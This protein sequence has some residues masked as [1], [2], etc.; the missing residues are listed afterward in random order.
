MADKSVPMKDSVLSEKDQVEILADLQSLGMSPEQIQDAMTSPDKTQM[1]VLEKYDHLIFED[2][3]KFYNA[4]RKVEWPYVG[5]C[6]HR[7][8]TYESALICANQRGTEWYVAKNVA[9]G[10]EGQLVKDCLEIEGKI[11]AL[12]ELPYENRT[13]PL[14]DQQLDQ[15]LKE[16]RKNIRMAMRMC[17]TKAI[18]LMPSN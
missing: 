6:D 14:T 11:I 15:E 17:S 8:K 2:I 4:Q 1:R 7:H 9:C 10:F 13:D 3:I 12:K 5:R 18:A 16:S